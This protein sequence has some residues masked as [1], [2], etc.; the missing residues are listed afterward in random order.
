VVRSGDLILL[1]SRLEPGWTGLPLSAAFPGFVDALVNRVARGH[2]I[3]LTVAVGDPA[4]LPGHATAVV[5]RDRRW[6]VEGGGLFRPPQTGAYFVLSDK[7][8]IGS[9]TAGPDQRNPTRA[10]GQGPACLTLAGKTPDRPRGS[11]WRPHSTPRA[12]ASLQGPLLWLALALAGIE[13]AGVRR[14]RTS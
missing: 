3:A 8:T 12:A 2:A 14:R 1:G 7:D 6:Q 10:G 4:E 5:R 9:L 11:G 13:L